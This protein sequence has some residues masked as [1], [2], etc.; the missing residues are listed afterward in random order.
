[1][2]TNLQPEQSVSSALAGA[3]LMNDLPVYTACQN[4]D[5]GHIFR[6]QPTNFF[7]NPVSFCH[8]PKI[9]SSQFL[10]K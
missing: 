2:L 10:P 7:L 3:F 5:A 6:F 9:L 8:P 1:M 4:I